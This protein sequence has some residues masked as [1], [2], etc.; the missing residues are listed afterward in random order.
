MPA[1]QV[2]PADI[3]NSCLCLQVRRAA[4][5]AARLYDEALAGA[6][7]TNGQFTLLSLLASDPGLGMGSVADEMGMD[8]STVIAALK[9]LTDR[10]LVSVEV[11]RNDRRARQLGLTPRGRETLRAALP[12]WRKA[13]QDMLQRVGETD[14][15]R[16]REDLA[17]MAA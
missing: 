4:R 17:A 8:R 12:L 9:P 5:A 6:G 11:D 14:V 13:Q 1:K 16:L 2:H 15:D 7:L 3:R 10:G